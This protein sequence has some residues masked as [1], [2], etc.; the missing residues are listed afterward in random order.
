[1]LPPCSLLFFIFYCIL[2]FL[3]FVLIVTMKILLYFLINNLPFLPLYRIWHIVLPFT[4]DTPVLTSDIHWCFSEDTC[5]H[6]RRLG[7]RLWFLR[8]TSVG[9]NKMSVWHDLQGN[10]TCVRPNDSRTEQAWGCTSSSWQEAWQ[11]T[12]L[13]CPG[14][15]LLS[16]LPSGGLLKVLPHSCALLYHLNLDCHEMFHCSTGTAVPLLLFARLKQKFVTYWFLW[17][18]LLSLGRTHSKV[19]VEK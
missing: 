3:L 16:V 2:P 14:S 13:M 18:T 12:E 8:Q 7:H 1:M 17:F 19:N 5:T 9:G 6:C 10:I 4:G 15:W 11:T